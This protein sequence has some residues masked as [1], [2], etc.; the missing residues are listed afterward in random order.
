MLVMRP[1]ACQATLHELFALPTRRAEP[2]PDRAI[3][4][5]FMCRSRE[6]PDRSHLLN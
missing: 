4:G 6:A 1:N 3:G 5:P 2:N